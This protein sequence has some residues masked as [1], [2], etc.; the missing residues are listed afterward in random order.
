VVGRGQR[1]LLDDRVGRGQR[2]LLDDRR[3]TRF[4]SD[5]TRSEAALVLID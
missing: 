4:W 5:P 1:D 3:A 2:D